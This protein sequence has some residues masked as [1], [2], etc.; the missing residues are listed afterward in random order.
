MSPTIEV[1]EEL[2]E[3]VDRHLAEGKPAKNFSRR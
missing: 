3:R 1:G 2:L